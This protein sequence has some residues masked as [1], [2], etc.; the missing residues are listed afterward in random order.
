MR[1]PLIKFKTFFSKEKGLVLALLMFCNLLQAQ[2]HN[3]GIL[4]VASNTILYINSGDLT[5]GSASST[6]TSKALPYVSTDG[7]ICIGPNAGF[8]TDGTNTKFINGYSETKNTTA[9]NL[10][11][12][13]ETVY[14]PIQVTPADDSGVKATYVKASPLVAYS[15]GL[16]AAVTAVGTSEYWI[17]TGANAVISLSWRSGSGLS[18]FSYPDLSIVGY[19]SGKWEII[20]SAIDATSKFGG[21]S[22]M[23]GSGSITSSTAVNLTQYDAFAIGEKGVTCFDIN[24]SGITRTWNGSSWSS[25]PT[26]ADAVT[27]N[28]NYSGGSF[29]CYALNLNGY[30]VTLSG[31][32]SVE[33]VD[34][35]SGSGTIKITGDA[36]LVQYK[37]GGTKPNIEITRTTRS[38]KRFD[39]VYWGTPVEENVFS[40]LSN[41]IANGVSTAGAFDYMYKYV[42]GDLT[43]AGG[44][45]NL[46]ST[47]PG[48]GFITRVKQQAPFVDGT[49][50]ATIDLKFTGTANNGDVTVAVANVSGDDTSARNNNLLANPYPSAID[51]DKF[52]TVNNDIIDGAV[53]LWRANTSN[54]GTG[55]EAYSVADYIAYTK[56][57]STAYSGT[58]SSSFNGKIAAGQGFK[59]RALTS[60][61]VT[62]TNCM[63]VAGNNGQFYRTNSY[64]QTTTQNADRFLLKLKA[65]N[66]V[67]NQIVVAYLPETTQEYDNMYDA[68]SLTSSPTNLYSMLDDGSRKLVINARPTFNPSDVVKLGVAKAAN[69]TSSLYID[70]AQT[71]GIFSNN[72]PIYLYDTVLN[73]YHNF[74]NG[75]Y[76]FTTNVAQDND[77][78]KIVYQNSSLGNV[79]HVDATTYAILSDNNLKIQA[80]TAMELVNV[81]DITGR[82]VATVH[83]TNT[84]ATSVIAP[85]NQ[86]QGVYLVKV[87]LINGKIVTTKLLNRQ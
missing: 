54:S 50:S 71:E 15:G 36:N 49:T 11:I 7:K 44:W 37:S 41:A 62:F 86:A 42:S 5:F 82:L 75:A 70:I 33:V 55:G 65:N 31:T 25:T 76:E 2:L 72:Q 16:D 17:I 38:M 73:N 78:F 20:D 39:Y 3:D 58:S 28:A 4:H 12:G 45:Q 8:I 56:A 81:Y 10:P 14:A 9:T 27:L 30:D 77:R 68:Q 1:Q 52:L 32:Q 87:K 34:G 53:Y 29:Q 83:P 18:T 40:Q 63:R 22:S 74:A 21:T 46:T 43:T 26:L 79:D 6:T 19:K 67:V 13:S 60:G 24:S 69:L 23:S 64:A 84:D 57:G 61:N 66:E 59:V 35:V 51:V 80:S 48:K 85:F 47:S